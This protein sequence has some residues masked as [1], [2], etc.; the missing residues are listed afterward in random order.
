MTETLA[1]LDVAI[2]GAELLAELHDALTRY[3]ILPSPEATDAVALWIAATHGQPAWERATRLDVTSREKRCG[4][5][6]LL[7]IIEATCHDPLITVNISAA[8]LARSIGDDPPSLLL[9][10]ADTVFG[11]GIKGDDKAETLRGLINAGHQRNRPYIRWDPVARKPESCPT[12]AMAAL[13]GIGDLPDTIADR[14]VIVRMRRR[15][16]GENVAAFRMRRDTPALHQ[17]RDQLGAWVRAHLDELREAQPEHMPVDDRAYDNWTPLAAIADIAGA[18]WPA[19]ARKAAGILTAEADASATGTTL[20]VRLLADLD[21]VWADDEDRLP[22]AVILDRLHALPEAPWA[23][24]YGKALNDS[25]LAKLLAR[26]QISPKQIRVGEST[27][28]GYER[29]ALEDAW[30]RYLPDAG[31]KQN[32]HNKQNIAGQSVVE[33]EPVL[34]TSKQENKRSPLTSGVLLLWMFCTTLPR[35]TFRA[36]PSKSRVICSARRCYL[37]TAGPKARSALRPTSLTARAAHAASR[38]PTATRACASDAGGSRDRPHLPRSGRPP[39]RPLQPAAA[40]PDPGQSLRRA[41]RPSPAVDHLAA[42]FTHSR[43]HAASG[44]R[45]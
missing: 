33:S 7:D 34:D 19:R 40:M 28:R 41:P 22:T 29:A 30:R 24:Y 42:G 37:T 14:A 38:S 3:V 44:A 32:I 8:A 1:D 27:P 23:D 11:K 5:S 35:A 13:A 25:G 26:Y 43:P 2:D 31:N 18:D 21:G 12:F 15:A 10:E 4:K 9:D 17:L 39:V 20:S 36:R 6:R 45:P 16:P